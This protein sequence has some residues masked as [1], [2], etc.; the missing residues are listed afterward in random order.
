MQCNVLFIHIARVW[1]LPAEEK[2]SSAQQKNF[3]LPWKEALTWL[4]EKQAYWS[5]YSRFLHIISK[6]QRKVLLNPKTTPAQTTYHIGGPVFGNY[7]IN[8]IWNA[9]D[10]MLYCECQKTLP[11][12]GI[13]QFVC[14]CLVLSKTEI[15]SV[16]KASCVCC[17]IL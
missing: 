7:M 9:F 16:V 11:N 13:L 14:N 3:Y 4:H 8:S 1:A 17:L 6:T 2:K 15:C 12:I 10:T 5:V